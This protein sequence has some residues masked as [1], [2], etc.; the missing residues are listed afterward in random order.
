MW[1]NL[2]KTE[3]RIQVYVPDI[4]RRWMSTAVVLGRLC[5]ACNHYWEEF[6]FQI[7]RIQEETWLDES[8]IKR[9][10]KKLKDDWIITIEKRWLPA[11]NYY[12]I[13]NKL[14]QIDTHSEVN[15]TPQESS[16]RYDKNNNK[17]IIINNINIWAFDFFWSAYPKRKWKPK[18]QQAYEKII[19]SGKATHE[20]I[21]KWL[22]Q[23][24]R[25][26]ALHQ[27]PEQFIK[28]PQWWLNEARRED[29]CGEILP[30]FDDFDAWFPI[31]DKEAKTWRP[32]IDWIVERSGLPRDQA[33]DIYQKRKFYIIQ[34]AKWL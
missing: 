7:S 23:Y 12:I 22:D 25:E 8:T 15:L 24:K 27:T 1:L 3:N 31:L 16:K 9:S 28:R 33:S 2:R 20:Q 30:A 18:A 19:K 13:T 4:K 34:K 11:K 26:I 32:K 17:E 21:M 5:N 14:S 29:E 6:F 10:L